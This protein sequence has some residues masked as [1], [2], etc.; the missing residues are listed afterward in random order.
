MSTF[1][2]A[3]AAPRTDLEHARFNMVEQQ[4]RPWEV[5]D[6]TVLDLL[7]RVHREDFVPD[8]HRALAFVDM[9]IPLGHGAA[10]LSPK[11]EARMLQELAVQ[12]SDTILEIGTGSGYMTTLL[13]S[14]GRHVYSVDIVPEFTRQAT[15][16]LASHGISNVT[17]ATADA[18]RGWDQHGPYDVIVLTGSVPVLPDSFQRSLNPGGRLLAVVGEPPAMQA[19]LIS[20]AH[21]GACR[22]VA[23]FETCIAPLKNAQQPQRFVF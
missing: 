9:E 14:V 17:L 11:L 12:S 4:I 19:R 2:S 21:A 15:K 10:M 22:S 8:E 16:R 3:V 6:P 7:M 18:A 1:A 23:L 20:C 13:A 5:L